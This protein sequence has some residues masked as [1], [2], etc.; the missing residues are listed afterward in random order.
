MTVEPVSIDPKWIKNRLANTE[1]PKIQTLGSAKGAL[2]T[3]PDQLKASP[4]RT[5][6]PG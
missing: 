4:I 1:I 6:G 5:T 2:R 3:P